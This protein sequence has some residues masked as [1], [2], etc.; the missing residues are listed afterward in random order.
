MTDFKQFT[1]RIQNYTP[2][3]LPFERLI[4]YYQNLAQMLGE[5]GSMHLLEIT[6]GSHATALSVEDIAVARIEQ[7]L[8]GLAVDAVPEAALK[9]R[10]VIGRMLSEDGTSA[11]FEDDRGNN[12]V[13]FPGPNLDAAQPLR[14]RD[15]ASI[16]GELYHIAGKKSDAQIRLQT[17]DYGVVFCST[18][19]A[20]AR[21]MRDYLFE[22]IKVSGRAQWT[23]DVETGRWDIGSLTV[24][25][26][27][28]VV[29]E[30]LKMAVERVRELNISWPDDPLGE[31]SRINS[32]DDAA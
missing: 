21:D 26:F 17:D 13:V 24:T 25:D 8:E 1:F 11:T 7:R 4:E 22:E 27:V 5:S 23:K 18:T 3:T 19:K 12:V 30:S 6:E 9:A 31:L 14:F 28:P 16:V 29:K 10:A 2:E 32:D 20:I 15:T